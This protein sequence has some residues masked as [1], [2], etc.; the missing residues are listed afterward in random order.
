MKE[1]I[2]LRSGASVTQINQRE[3][4][5]QGLLD[6]NMLK[7]MHLRCNGGPIAYSQL[8]DG[9][10]KLWFDPSEVTEEDPDI[11]FG[12]KGKKETV[13]LP[14]G[15]VIERMTQKKATQLGLYPADKIASMH[16]ELFEEP[17]AF[18]RR[19]DRTPLMLYDRQ[20]T[21]RKP[22]MCAKCGKNVRY[23][24]KLCRDCYEE[25]LAV[26]RAEGDAHRNAFYNMD[27]AKVLFFDLE[28]TGFYD[29][30]EILSVSIYNA[31]GEKIMDTLVRPTHT[32]KWKRTEKIH[33]IT[34]EMVKDAATITELAPEIKEIFARADVIIAYG[35]STD[36]SHIKN[37]YETDAEKAALKEKVRDAASEFVRYIGEHRPDITHA[38]LT[39]AMACFGIEWDGVAHTSIA[40]T[41]GCMKVWEKLFPN[42]FIN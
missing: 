21:V 32:K 27:R 2:R 7:M 14:S 31:F 18:T 26:R 25:E 30:D 41:I 35:V 36:Y 16:L 42:Y 3:A 17:V 1:T 11:W 37:I 22:L 15:S 19:R 23:R 8:N 38:S 5:I 39:D 29:H 13:T 33:G 10:I 24:R 9:S 12:S 6:R 20:T 4:A 34:P 28:L 40:D